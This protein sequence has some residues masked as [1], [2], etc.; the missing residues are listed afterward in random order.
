MFRQVVG[1]EFGGYYTKENGDGVK[2]FDDAGLPVLNTDYIGNDG[3]WLDSTSER[4]NL[5][6]NSTESLTLY[7]NWNPRK[8]ILYHIMIVSG[9][10]LSL[11]EVLITL[12]M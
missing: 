12:H 4:N 5:D 2:V 1:F 9:L 10:I 6:D 8:T 3:K 11:M 7:A